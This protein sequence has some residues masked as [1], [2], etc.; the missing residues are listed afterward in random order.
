MSAFKKKI[1]GKWYEVVAWYASKAEAKQTA[2]KQRKLGHHKSV[3]IVK[4]L[5]DRRYARYYVCVR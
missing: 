1:G 3:R 2:E 5:V 4:T